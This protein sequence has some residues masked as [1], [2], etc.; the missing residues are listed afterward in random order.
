MHSICDEKLIRNLWSWNNNDLHQLCEKFFT[1]NVAGD[2][3]FYLFIF[4]IVGHN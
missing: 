4:L 2:I 1:I 3:L